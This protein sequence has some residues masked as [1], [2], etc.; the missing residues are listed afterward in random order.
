MNLR[1]WHKTRKEKKKQEQFNRG[2]DYAIGA[3]ARGE[4]KP[5]ELDA[6]QTCMDRNQFDVGMD[7]AIAYAILHGLTKD[8]RI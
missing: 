4:K 7:Q 6:E 1:K 2:F 5:L 8:N 3:I